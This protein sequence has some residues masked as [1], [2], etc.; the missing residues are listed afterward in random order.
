MRKAALRKLVPRLLRPGWP[1]EARGIVQ[2]PLFRAAAADSPPHGRCLN[3][4]CGE[5]LF[6]DFLESFEEITE[7]VNIDIEQ[8]R[9]SE[10][11]HDPRNTDAVGSVT[12][13]PLEDESVD[14][15]L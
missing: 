2:E 6:S 14:W 1:D 9:M 11:R 3:A 10:R 15:V 7:I 12:E 13:L 4:G 5:G 8:P